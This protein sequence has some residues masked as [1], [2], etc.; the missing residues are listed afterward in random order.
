MI[1]CADQLTPLFHVL[2]DE[3]FKQQIV[4]ADETTIQVLKEEGREAKSK[5]YSHK[6]CW[7][8]IG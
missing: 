3:L 1:A 6:L 2:K 8:A 5:S 7:R 4:H